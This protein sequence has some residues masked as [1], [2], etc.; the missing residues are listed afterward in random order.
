M[1]GWDELPRCPKCDT[2]L[3]RTLG[4]PLPAGRYP[5]VCPGCRFDVKVSVREIGRVYQCLLGEKTT[6]ETS[7]TL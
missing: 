5:L 6:T 1:K 2:G 3:L 7:S 4:E